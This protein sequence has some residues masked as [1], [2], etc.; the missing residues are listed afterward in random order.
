MHL[1]PDVL[2]SVHASVTPSRAE[3]M[4][5]RSDVLASI[6]RGYVDVGASVDGTWQVIER[7]ALATRQPA[8]MVA[9]GEVWAI[10]PQSTEALI[11][12]LTVERAPD[13]IVDGADG[14]TSAVYTVDDDEEGAEVAEALVERF[15]ACGAY[16]SDLAEVSIVIAS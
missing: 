4:F 16:D 8:A 13:D 12:L 7:Y 15:H 6:R 9:L 3:R 5:Q 11:S 14:W 10:V 2:R 1:A